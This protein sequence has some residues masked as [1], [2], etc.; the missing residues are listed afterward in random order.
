MNIAT[1]PKLLNGEARSSF[2]AMMI[3][4]RKLKKLSQ[5]DLSLESGVSQRHISFME[6]GRAKPSRSM[7]LALA[8]VLNIPF[9][10]QNQLLNV[11]GFSSEFKERNL[12]NEDMCAV[13]HALEMSLAHH[14]PYPA[15]VADRNWNLVMANEASQRFIGL[16]GKPEEVWQ[17]VDPSGNKNI[18]RLTFHSLG[19][20]PLI[21]NWNEI[22]KLL[23]LRL[24]REVAID[25][26]NDFL[27]ALLNE[28]VEISGLEGVYG[29]IDNSTAIAPV[30]PMEMTTAGITLKTFSMI[31]SFGT[32]QDITASELKV[33][34]FFPADDV[35][36]LFF[37]QIAD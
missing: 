12:D 9:R 11:A 23:L 33:E 36:K 29:A 13:H 5:L 8:Q 31:S 34:T 1:K 17:R 27:S 18:Y 22:A 35:T 37:E 10:D 26:S 25:P 20:Q 28:V 32:A 2:S 24:Q 21:S 16:I 7:V 6:S 14:E 15:I 4:W 3:K 30:F 19:L